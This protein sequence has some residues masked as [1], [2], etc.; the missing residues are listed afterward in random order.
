[1]ML[2]D[3]IHGRM[4][5]F[6]SYFTRL[7][8]KHPFFVVVIE[9]NYLETFVLTEKLVFLAISNFPLKTILFYSYVCL[10]VCLLCAPYVVM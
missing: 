7:F 9:G 6:K 1:M 5:R 8:P 2:L 10:P 3:L 4:P